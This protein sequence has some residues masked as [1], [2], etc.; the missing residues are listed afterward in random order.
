MLLYSSPKYLVICND[1]NFSEE[2]PRLIFVNCV[3]IIISFVG[4]F[5]VNFFFFFVFNL[6]NFNVSCILC[7]YTSICISRLE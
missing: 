5:R 1:N 6:F 2:G 3:R 7:G 4:K